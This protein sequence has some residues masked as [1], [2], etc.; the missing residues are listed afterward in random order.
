MNVTTIYS[1]P[2]QGQTQAQIYLWDSPTVIVFFAVA[3]LGTITWLLNEYGKRS[4]IEHNQKEERY[5]ALINCLKD[6]YDPKDPI[7]VKQFIKE[8]NLCL[9]YC[10]DSVIRKGNEFLKTYK[11]DV[12]SIEKKGTLNKEK[13]EA[14][15]AFMFAIREDAFKRWPWPSWGPLKKTKL[16]TD[17]IKAWSQIP[18]MIVVRSD[19]GEYLVSIAGASTDADKETKVIK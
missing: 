3:F 9:L 10:P 2:T 7:D 19:Y 16:T 12:I 11:K 6:Y 13:D 4:R 5:L 17:E 14:F 8:F 1:L 15:S 18:R